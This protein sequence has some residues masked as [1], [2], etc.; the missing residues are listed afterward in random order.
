MKKKK[1]LFS[2]FVEIIQLSDI[3][4]TKIAKREKKN[5][6]KGV[7]EEEKRKKRRRKK[8]FQPKFPSRC[9]EN[10]MKFKVN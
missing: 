1:S 3:K 8:S 4:G 7:D 10:I 6:E 5:I 9:E 2:I